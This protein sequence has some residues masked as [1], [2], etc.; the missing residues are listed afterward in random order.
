MG[1]V[2]GDCC[3][4]DVIDIDQHSID[5]AEQLI[6]QLSICIITWNVNG[7]HPRNAAV[8]RLLNHKNANIYAIGLQETVDL[9]VSKMTKVHDLA[10]AWEKEID[11]VLNADSSRYIHLQTVSLFGILLIVFIK[12]TIDHS[13]HDVMSSKCPTGVLGVGGNKGAVGIRFTIY[14]TSICFV[15]CHLAA[16]KERL[17]ERNENYAKIM[18]QLL[19][20]EENNNCA[21]CTPNYMDIAVLQHDV[22]FMFGDLNYR[23]EF[24]N[25]DFDN[26]CKLSDNNKWSDLLSRD[27]LSKAMENG[28]AFVDF[29]ESKID[30]APTYRFEVGTNEYTKQRI[31]SY[32]DRIL[33]KLIDYGQTFTKINDIVYEMQLARN[34]SDHKPVVG[35]YNLHQ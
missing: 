29:S 16:R 11:N 32:C 5:L 23:L 13:V 31:P 25:T 6:R 24:E 8:D 9:S 21:Q 28:A 15:N 33:W 3:Q 1:E 34:M 17:K 18:Q 27:Q 19:F 4:G 2:F 26:V 12:K 30:F 7:K 14:D 22:V 35:L 20:A 10:E